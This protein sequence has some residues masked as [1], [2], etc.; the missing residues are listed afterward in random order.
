MIQKFFFELPNV[1]LPSPLHYYSRGPLKDTVKHR[2]IIDRIQEFYEQLGVFSKEAKIPSSLF[3]Q[4]LAC[5]TIADG[6]SMDAFKK[7]F[8]GK[9]SDEVRIEEKIFELE[10]LQHLFPEQGKITY[11]PPRRPWI[12][13]EAFFIKVV[14][15][16]MLDEEDCKKLINIAFADKPANVLKVLSLRGW[17][18]EQVARALQKPPLPQDSTEQL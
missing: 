7:Y 12:I 8:T 5:A 3:L 17:L 11:L 4:A 9:Y 13:G 18:A 10:H 1:E 15:A 16:Y 2:L 6:L 14:N